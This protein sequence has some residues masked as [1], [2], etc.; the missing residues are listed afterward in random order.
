[1]SDAPGPERGPIDIWMVT[2]NKAGHENQI[3][4][5]VDRLGAHAEVRAHRIVAPKRPW[6]PPW[7]FRRGALADLPDPDLILCA[8][9]RT[10]RLALSI[11]RRRGGVLVV[12]M[13]PYIGQRH[14]DLCL[15]PRHDEPERAPNI[16]ITTGA[17]VNVTPSHHHDERRGVFLVGGPSS[18]FGMDVEAVL[19]QV[20]AIVDAD[21][22]I[23]WSLTTSRRTPEE[24]A[25]KL[26]SLERDT[27]EFIHAGKT[28]RGWVHER[29]A[30]SAHA[31]I[32]ADSVSMVCESLTSGCATGVLPMPAKNP[33]GRVQRCI[34]DLRDRGLITA[35]DVW[36]ETGELPAPR[37][38][39]D[40]ASRCASLILRRFFPGLGHT[41]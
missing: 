39:L 41:P 32:T 26:A 20:E 24:A 36:R 4:G 16:E 17:L 9:R 12:C 19:E 14:F 15:I 28:P 13:R 37:E 1:M 30:E 10:H 31:W 2:D 25:R 27:L 3:L 11:K 29:L 21:P 8:G 40:E 38:P 18:H 22:G 7:G 6:A 23:R 35:F 34:D 33:G 5:L